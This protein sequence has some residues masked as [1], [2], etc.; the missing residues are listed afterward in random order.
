[1]NIALRLR[2]LITIIARRV[3]QPRV[4]QTGLMDKFTM[5]ALGPL[6]HYMEQDQLQAA[7]AQYRFTIND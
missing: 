2:R 7:I 5:L 1:M 4:R 6:H 3:F